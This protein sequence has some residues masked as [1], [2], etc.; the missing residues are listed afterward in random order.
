MTWDEVQV[1]DFVVVDA[2]DHFETGGEKGVE[3]PFQVWGEVTHKTDRVLEIAGAW[4]W[5]SDPD[6]DFGEP[7]I[8]YGEYGVV[9][10]AVNT[11]LPHPGPACFAGLRERL[12]AA[13]KR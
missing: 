9:R 10:G 6:W 4:V 7:P 5:M 11:I 1:G 3:Y 13:R 8:C 12:L 2:D